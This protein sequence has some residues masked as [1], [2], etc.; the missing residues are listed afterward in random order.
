MKLSLGQSVVAKNHLKW[1]N[2]AEINPGDH[3]YVDR[4]LSASAE[5]HVKFMKSRYPYIITEREADRLFG[6]QVSIADRIRACLAA[7]K[8]RI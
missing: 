1:A 7:R 5:Y 4:I 3:G 6:N 8:A 2:G